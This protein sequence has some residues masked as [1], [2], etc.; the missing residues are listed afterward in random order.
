MCLR[1]LERSA[2]LPT[3]LN[4]RLGYDRVA[5][6]V[7]ESLASGQ[8]LREIAIEKNLLTEAEYEALIASSTGPNL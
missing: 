3:L 8:T 5:E 6:L 4:P 1:H 2:G 7:K